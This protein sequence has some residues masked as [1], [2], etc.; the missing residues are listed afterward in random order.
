MLLEN[1][2]LAASFLTNL[3]NSATQPFDRFLE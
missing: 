1:T 2:A 3:K